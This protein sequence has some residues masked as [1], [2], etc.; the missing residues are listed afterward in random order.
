MATLRGGRGLG[1]GLG[2]QGGGGTGNWG[3]AN[4]PPPAPGRKA[5]KK[6]K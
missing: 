2:R 5:T 3:T 4:Q 6:K 1:R